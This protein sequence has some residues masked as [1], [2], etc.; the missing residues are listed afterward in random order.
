MRLKRD[1]QSGIVLVIV[2]WVLVLLGIMVGSYLGTIRTDTAITANWLA[3]AKSRWA[4]NAGV[5]LALLRM[6]Q[7]SSNRWTSGDTVHQLEYG[8]IRFT[9]RLVDE[10]GKIDINHASDD[11]LAALFRSTKASEEEIRG[12]IA[13]IMR[14]RLNNKSKQLLGKPNVLDQFKAKGDSLFQNIEELARLPGMKPEMMRRLKPLITTYSGLNGVN[15]DVAS[16]EVLMIL[17]GIEVEQAEQF[18]TMRTQRN[19]RDSSLIGS[20][21]NELVHNVRGLVV[22]IQVTAQMPDGS[23]GYASV[24]VRLSERRRRNKKPFSIVQWDEPVRQYSQQ[25]DGNEMGM[26]DVESH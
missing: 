21:K 20:V 23:K 19:T 18:L 8:D 6:I 11:L 25:L 2:L 9:I 17:P 24:I 4:A 3:N 14:R 26:D 1:K 12:L 16:A 15:P 5:Q 10:A 7:K 13:D 22:D